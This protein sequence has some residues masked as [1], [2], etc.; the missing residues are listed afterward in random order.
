MTGQKKIE[1]LTDSWYGFAIFAGIMAVVANGIGILTIG[2]AA[3]STVF[4]LFITFLIGRSLRNKNGIT[5][6]VLLVLAPLSA[7]LGV[8]G[9]WRM[10]GMFFDLWSWTMLVNAFVSAVG[11]YMNAK[12]LRVLLDGSVAAHFKT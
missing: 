4:S 3:F 11:V 8:F 6:F 5:R 9:V 1:Q 10:M 2:F 12:S 7:I